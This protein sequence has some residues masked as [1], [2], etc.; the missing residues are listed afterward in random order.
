MGGRKSSME[1]YAIGIFDRN[2]H[3]GGRCEQLRVALELLDQGKRRGGAG[4]LVGMMS[5]GDQD[6]W[7]SGRELHRRPATSETAARQCEGPDWTAF[8]RPPRLP[9]MNAGH[10]LNLC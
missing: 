6:R 3:P 7:F 9:D 10:R 8:I 5:R 1:R 2:D 4:N